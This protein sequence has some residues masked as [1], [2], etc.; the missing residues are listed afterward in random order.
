MGIRGRCKCY[1][2]VIIESRRACKSEDMVQGVKWES[3]LQ[4]PSSFSRAEFLILVDI[5]QTKGHDDYGALDEEARIR[6]M[7]CWESGSF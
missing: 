1:L 2:E 7:T 5:E 3:R 4:A 6:K